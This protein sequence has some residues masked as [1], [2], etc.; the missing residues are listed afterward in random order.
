MNDF[1]FPWT[2]QDI[3]Y[4]LNIP[5]DARKD[6][7]YIQCP[8]CGSSRLGFSL[9][10]GVGQCWACK[11]GYNNTTFYAMQKE[12]SVGEAIKE[13]KEKLNVKD[14][15]KIYNRPYKP[16]KI[17]KKEEAPLVSPEIRDRTYRALLQQLPLLEEHKEELLSRGFSL[18]KMLLA[19]YGSMREDLTQKEN[20][21]ICEDLIKEGFTI[22]GV[23]GF[24]QDYKTK[25]WRFMVTT[26]GII[27]P[28][29]D[30]NNNVVGLCIRKQNDKRK[31]VEVT[32]EGKE[33]LEP[34][35]V[36]L[37]SRNFNKGT[38]ASVSVHCNFDFK[39]DK[40]EMKYIPVLPENGKVILTEGSM[41]ADL[42]GLLLSEEKGDIVPIMSVPGVHALTALK[43]TIIEL[44]KY[45]LNEIMMAYDMDYLTNVS[46]QEA[47]KQ[48]ISIIKENDVKVTSAMKWNTSAKET[49]EPLKGIDDY[50]AYV[51][52]G[53]IPVK[54]A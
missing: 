19:G 16:E 46:V 35:Y 8:A 45:G 29:V 15:N 34:K 10:K 32:P 31:V 17:I 44:K 21:Q 14:D 52:K 39:W 22:E 30:Y 3:F 25:K 41:K 50:L 1:N 20:E 54:R 49:D 47:L 33:K 23:P 28:Q 18:E 9:V 42:T 27:C 24:Y 4:L 38:P 51:L 26:Q 43:K 40:K 12:I 5:F 48:T 37:T 53:I 2:T 7:V 36:W 11:K 13:I 6:T